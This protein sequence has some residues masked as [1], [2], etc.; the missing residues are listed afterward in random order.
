M[1]LV[2]ASVHLDIFESKKQHAA[3]RF[4]CHGDRRNQ[5]AATDKS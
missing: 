4:I 3:I 5:M 2:S 1:S